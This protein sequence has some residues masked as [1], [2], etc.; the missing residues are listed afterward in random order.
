MGH[1]SVSLLELGLL[2]LGKRLSYARRRFP[3]W[4]QEPGKGVCPWIQES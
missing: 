3:L 1:P 4:S 2:W